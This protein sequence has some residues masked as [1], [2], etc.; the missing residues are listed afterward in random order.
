[1]YETSAYSLAY[2]LVEIPYIIVS[3]ACFVLVFYF[4]LGFDDDVRRSSRTFV[5]VIR[6]TLLFG[7][8][9]NSSGTGCSM[10]YPQE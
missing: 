4:L 2:G 9:R 5:F 8:Q 10:H 1:M 3:S 7:R 6:D